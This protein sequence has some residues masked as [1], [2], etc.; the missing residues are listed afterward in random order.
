MRG[1]WAGHV[2][3]AW[4]CSVRMQGSRAVLCGA[5]SR[6]LMNYDNLHA[7]KL[8]CIDPQAHFMASVAYQSHPNPQHHV[9][10]TCARFSTPIVT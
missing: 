6:E 8:T 2:C 9:N 4:V 3:A 7:C 5:G 10:M 1:L